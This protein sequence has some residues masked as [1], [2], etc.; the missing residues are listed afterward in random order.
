MIRCH[1]VSLAYKQDQPVID[2]LS[3]HLEAGSFTFLAGASGAG[4][5][6]LIGLLGAAL[7]PTSGK[8]ELFGEN[9]ARL[10]HSALPAVRRRIGMVY[11]DYQLLPHLSVADNVALP[12]KV[13]GEPADDI[14]QK[15]RELL[16]WI[17]LSDLADARPDVLSGGQKQRVAIARAVIGN[18]ALILA[19]EP[20]GNLDHKLSM[21]LMHL[22]TSLNKAGTTIVFATHDEHLMSHFDYPVLQL[23]DGKVKQTRRLS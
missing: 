13:A 22:F 3:L 23:K 19:D 2:G 15:T 6:T 5:S 16:G 7:K 9:V 18:P 10:P 20:T 21:K 17:G 1:E 11:Q 8:L 12:L 4:K 14:V